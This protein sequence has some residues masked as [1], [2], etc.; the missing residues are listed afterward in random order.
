M[1]TLQQ[2]EYISFDGVETLKA[3]FLSFS[4]ANAVTVTSLS[5][6][7]EGVPL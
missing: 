3:Y 1:Y 4:S 7:V 2:K 5:A 6:T